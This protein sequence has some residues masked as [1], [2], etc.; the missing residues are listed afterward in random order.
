M[1]YAAYELF[2]PLLSPGETLVT[3]TLAL[4]QRSERLIARFNKLTAL[5]DRF[6]E[7]SV[8][9]ARKLHWFERLFAAHAGNTATH[10]Q[11]TD[12]PKCQR[13]WRA[14]ALRSVVAAKLFGLHV[15]APG[16]NVPEEGSAQLAREPRLMAGFIEAIGGNRTDNLFEGRAPYGGMQGADWGITVLLRDAPAFAKYGK[17][18]VEYQGEPAPRALPQLPK[19]SSW[20]NN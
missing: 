9:P 4:Q 14:N 3:P 12:W 7:Q 10:M 16:E 11:V 13:A 5:E 2:N 18:E 8:L 17:V 1:R 6:H 20:A 19:L 15:A